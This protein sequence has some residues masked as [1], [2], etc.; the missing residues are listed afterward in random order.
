MAKKQREALEKEFRSKKKAAPGFL[1][2]A[3]EEV[4]D[5]FKAQK[6]FQEAGEDIDL[7][8]LP[9]KTD[10]KLFAVKCREG[11]EQD[12]C[13]R[14]MESYFEKLG[15]HEEFQIFSVSFVPK[16]PGYLYF[17][18]FS[19]KHVFLAITGFF[20]L[21]QRNAR[22]IELKDRT[23]I[24]EK[25]P[26]RTL[27]SK[28][29]DWVRIKARG[30]YNGDLAQIVDIDEENERFNVKIVPRIHNG[31]ESELY[32]NETYK[33]KY[34]NIKQTKKFIGP[35]PAQRLFKE[36]D[37]SGVES[38][39]NQDR[40]YL[41]YKGNKYYNGLIYK[42]F[43]FKYIQ[44][45]NINPQF[46]ELKLFMTAE[47]DPNIL[48]ALVDQ[49]NLKTRKFFNGDKV[50]VINGDMINLEAEIVRIEDKVIHARPLNSEFSDTIQLLPSEIVKIFKK[51]D[52]VRVIEGVNSG[53]EGFVMKVQED[54][55]TLMSDGLS[56][57]IKAFVNDLVYC[58][59][60][61]RNIQVVNKSNAD[62]QQ[63]SKFDLIKL[64]DKKTVG[65][66]LVVG[67]NTLK[68]LDNFGNLQDVKNLQI[69]S[70]LGNKNVVARNEKGQ[71]F[72]IGDSVRILKGKYGGNVGSIKQI[73]GDILFLYNTDYTATLGCVI[74]KSNNCFLLTS[75]QN[76]FNAGP[77]G[78]DPLIGKECVIIKGAW[79]GY[80][81]VCRDANDR[82]VQ[83][84]LTSKCKK[85]DV[86]RELVKRLDE[87]ENLNNM[88]MEG[89]I[90]DAKTPMPGKSGS[91]QSPG[92]MNSPSYNPGGGWGME[93]PSYGKD[94]FNN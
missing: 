40:L 31:D 50:R 76:A 54:T 15:T 27:K 80:K 53:K 72:K 11:A 48:N 9:S 45:D 92:F 79:K 62:L 3:E 30:I 65:I 75:Q 7:A 78:L 82:S 42:R 49:N 60:S 38:M 46:E 13:N 51:G 88:S 23:K 94:G 17:E 14:I 70:K 64:N 52:Y 2:V 19:N 8:F 58:N 87:V 91:M 68:V 44:I 71:T 33:D 16:V 55:A 12:V 89:R 77:K 74:E 4:D 34:G 66:V 84:E 5:Y 93:S 6:H 83:L 47:D 25:D 20:E 59:D 29:G 21:D 32:R 86:K 1:N 22:L 63:Y 39:G 24:F 35:K 26:K 85:L 37:Y 36:S 69:E 41:K 61:T 90:M 73:Y 10:P 81:G 56:N 67:S 18:A 28:V 43:G 57:Q